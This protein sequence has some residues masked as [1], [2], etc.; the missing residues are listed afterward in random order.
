[1][2][3]RRPGAGSLYRM[4]I[5]N[6]VT[7]ILSDVTLSNGIAWSPDGATCYYVD[8]PLRR[9]DAFDFDMASGSLS[10][11]RPLVE[12]EEGIGNPDG[13]TVDAEGALWLVLARGGAVRRYAP[14]GRLIRTIHFPVQ[15]VTSCTFGGT[16]LDRLY[17]TSACVGRS[18]LELH[19][20][21][22][23]GALF[24]CDVGVHGMPASRFSG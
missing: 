15:T 10:C 21:P 19:A 6:R 18:E 24:S 23:S 9:V 1:T 20:E 2:I 3:D 17:V 11:R 8:T 4:D 16:S 22:L 14:D 13:L 5:D 7:E 12:L